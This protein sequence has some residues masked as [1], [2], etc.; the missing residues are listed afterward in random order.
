MFVLQ[1]NVLNSLSDGWSHTQQILPEL[2]VAVMSFIGIIATL[3]RGKKEQDEDEEEL[4]R[5]ID[6]YK[7]KRTMTGVRIA[8]LITLTTCVYAF[9]PRVLTAPFFCIQMV[10]FAFYAF[11][12]INMTRLLQYSS[13][14]LIPYAA[15]FYIF[16]VVYQIQPFREHFNSIGTWVGVGQCDEYFTVHGWVYLVSSAASVFYLVFSSGL[17]SDLFERKPHGQMDKISADLVKIGAKESSIVDWFYPRGWDV[18]VIATVFLC[19]GTRGVIPFVMLLIAVCSATIPSQYAAKLGYVLFAMEWFYLITQFIVNIPEAVKHDLNIWENFGFKRYGTSSESIFFVTQTLLI[20]VL[21][22]Y[23]RLDLDHFHKKK[24]NVRETVARDDAAE[25]EKEAAIRAVLGADYDYSQDDSESLSGGSLSSYSTTIAKL[26][27]KLEKL[28]NA[29]LVCAGLLVTLMVNTSH[30]IALI[31][32]YFCCLSKAT[33]INFV[34]MTFF[35]VFFVSPQIAKRFWSLLVSYSSCALLVLY[36]WQLDWSRALCDD[37]LTAPTVIGLAHWRNLYKDMIYQALIFVFTLV[38]WRILD[39]SNTYVDAKGREGVYY[40]ISHEE[41]P[42]FVGR[43]ARYYP[44]AFKALSYVLF[45]VAICCVAMLSPITVMS[46]VYLAFMCLVAFSPSALTTSIF[47]V[48]NALF[49]AMRYAFQMKAI[50]DELVKLYPAR[51]ARYLPLHD[52]GL[53]VWTGKLFVHLFNDVALLIASVLFLRAMKSSKESKAHESTDGTD[54]E[55][56]DAV[57][58]N[59][60]KR[61]VFFFMKLLYLVAPLCVLIAAGFTAVNGDWNVFSFCILLIIVFTLPKS[62]GI[63]APGNILLAS[64]TVIL[65]SSYAFNLTWTDEAL[66]DFRADIKWLGITVLERDHDDVKSGYKLSPHIVEYFLVMFFTMIKKLLDRFMEKNYVKFENAIV[67]A[68]K[69][70]MQRQRELLSKAQQAHEER[71]AL[72][73][74]R[75][76]DEQE[77]EKDEADDIAHRTEGAQ[78]NESD[79]EMAG[80]GVEGKGHSGEHPRKDTHKK[81]SVDLGKIPYFSDRYFD[82]QLLDERANSRQFDLLR[83]PKD[84]DPLDKTAQR[85]HYIRWYVSNIFLVL[86]YPICLVFC[87]AAL[88]ARSYD[89]LGYLYLAVVVSAVA[90]L[91]REGSKL[92]KRLV[93]GCYLVIA[94]LIVFQYVCGLGLPPLPHGYHSSR[95]DATW[96]WR[97]WGLDMRRVL[98]LDHPKHKAALLADLAALLTMTRLGLGSVG[99]YDGIRSLVSTEFPKRLRSAGDWVVSGII[100]VTPALVLL[101]LF[102]AGTA[103]MDGMS[104]IYLVL[105]VI[106]F[107]KGRLLASGNDTVWKVSRIINIFV[108]LVQIIFYTTVTV[109]DNFGEVPSTVINVCTFIGF[110][111]GHVSSTI[112]YNVFAFYVLAYHSTTYSYLADLVSKV[113]EEDEASDKRAFNKASD[114]LVEEANFTCSQWQQ[115]YD[116]REN[117]MNHIKAIRKKRLGKLNFGLGGQQIQGKDDASEGGDADADADGEMSKQKQHKNKYSITYAILDPDEA[118]YVISGAELYYGKLMEVLDGI[119]TYFC[120][121][122]TKELIEAIEEDEDDK[123]Q[124]RHRRKAVKRAAKALEKRKREEEDALKTEEELARDRIIRK[125]QADA[126][127]EKK[128]EEKRRKK[129][130]EK[131][132]KNWK[133]AEAKLLQYLCRLGDKDAL[134]ESERR[135]AKQELRKSKELPSRIKILF[136]GLVWTIRHS[137]KGICVAFIIVNNAI[138]GSIFTFVLTLVAFGYILLS[139]NPKPGR[140]FWN[141]VSGFVIFMA[142]LK[143]IF[144]MPGFYMTRNL[145]TGRDSFGFDINKTSHGKLPDIPDGEKAVYG[146]SWIYVLGVQQ[147]HDWFVFAALWDVLLLGAIYVHKTVM[148]VNG[149]WREEMKPVRKNARRRVAEFCRFLE[150]QAKNRFR[151]PETMADEVLDGGTTDVV[152]N[153]SN[154]KDDKNDNIN[155]KDNKNNKNDNKNNKNGDNDKNNDKNSDGN[156]YRQYNHK[157]TNTET[158]ASSTNHVLKKNEKNDR[159]AVSFYDEVETSDTE[160]EYSDMGDDLSVEYDDLGNLHSK[161]DRRR[162]SGSKKPAP[163]MARMLSDS[164]VDEDVVPQGS[165][166]RIVSRHPDPTKPWTAEYN[167]RQVKVNPYFASVVENEQKKR[168]RARSC[169]RDALPEHHLL[170]S[171]ERDMANL[172]KFVLFR[173]FPSLRNAFHPVYRYFNLLVYDPLKMGTDFYTSTFVLELICLV[174]VFFFPND[175]A[176]TDVG[177][178]DLVDRSSV[179]LRLVFIL[180]A[181]FAVIVIDRVVFVLHSLQAKLVVQYVTL[182]VYLVMLM[183]VFPMTSKTTFRGSWGL[184]GCFLFKCFYWSRSAH[185]I[186]EGYQ[187]TFEKR[188]MYSEINDLNGYLFEI[189]SSVPF[190][191]ELRTIL[192]WALT[193][194]SLSIFMNFKYESLYLMLYDTKSGVEEETGYNRRIGTPQRRMYKIMY[195]SFLFLILCILIW[196]P[197]LILSSGG[198]TTAKAPITQVNFSVKFDGYMDLYQQMQHTLSDVS[199]G[200]FESLRKSYPGVIKKDDRGMLQRVSLKDHSDYNWDIT[201]PAFDE[202][203]SRLKG[204]TERKTMSVSIGIVRDATSNERVSK[205]Y[206]IEISPDA[207][208]QLGDAIQ[209]GDGSMVRIPSFIPRF[210]R[211]PGVTGELTFGGGT[212]SA[213]LGFVKVVDQNSRQKS[214]Y[215]KLLGEGNDLIKITFVDAYMPIGFASSFASIGLVGLYTTYIVLVFDMVREYFGAEATAIPL[216]HMNNAD[217]LFE[218]CED[219]LLARQYKDLVLEESIFCELIEIFRSTERLIEATREKP[220]E[221]SDDDDDDDKSNNSSESESESSDD[222]DESI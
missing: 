38:Q 148:E 79:G 201:D 157:E 165:F 25:A 55:G 69:K 1:P 75:L 12:K 206:D 220:E 35:L 215:W 138:F 15:A 42:A 115:R 53:S 113:V 22:L 137:T 209:R 7:T 160:S 112:A 122:E 54:K 205:D 181:M 208:H 11:S 171:Y 182:V 149:Y 186:R 13:L 61:V 59:T 114:K 50:S 197:M 144:N 151:V 212:Q 203:V 173:Q 128:K 23:I 96:P 200:A 84:F 217:D 60:V 183:W 28:K 130:L 163:V 124:E 187:I 9:F 207:Q 126:L 159:K 119:F 189:Y 216:E 20:F 196:I 143:F 174:F 73:K 107:V 29:A 39:P 140:R 125:R 116:E 221:D 142:L 5:L 8:S 78:V 62:K 199:N 193:D 202:L 58:M 108:I 192:D 105:A 4:E 222:D 86:R 88:S 32:V 33:V 106:I 10:M 162:N 135:R 76:N 43:A 219:L 132:H 14:V 26:N 97:S 67:L 101:L 103:R 92:S 185:Q 36:L 34:Y 49:V 16:G 123:I 154:D 175:F 169:H 70:K 95:Y 91:S 184:I 31:L 41:P 6:G 188:F 147:R 195:G 48:I 71:R 98:L 180:I 30:V 191:F 204:S 63:T 90:V 100:H 19:L 52:L 127:K 24:E 80:T 150:L 145:I 51:V 210:V 117:R 47:V 37:T 72:K 190:L 2:F 179:S 146:Y 170:C 153:D 104:L 214:F 211:L 111:R 218:L 136:D 161:R 18:I 56:Q 166:L 44:E 87:C 118:D 45:I 82:E 40:L 176:N 139:K 66:S 129:E 17:V 194:T 134:E 120:C 131:A 74:R 172:S 141:V 110:N 89:V 83:T 3:V 99:F 168:R 64:C 21:S 152:N 178:D 65:I 81:F 77:K 133:H 177:T 109:V 213:E 155:D 121:A 167:G 27:I 156:I 198:L 46:I 85:S 93:A 158:N 164:K 68:D 102:I 94:V 57:G